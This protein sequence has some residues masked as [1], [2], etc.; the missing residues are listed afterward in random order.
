LSIILG[1][2]T[3]YGYAEQD[4]LK[5]AAADAKNEA[6]AAKT[7]RDWYKYA[8]LQLKHYTGDLTNKEAEELNV[9]PGK[10][11][12]SEDKAAYDSVFQDLDKRLVKGRAF[13]SY[14]EKV[15]RLE[16]ELANTRASLQAEQTSLKKEREEHLRMVAVKDQ[17]VQ[18]LTSELQKAHADNVADRDKLEKDMIAKLQELGGVSEE[19]EKV[20]KL[21]ATEVGTLQKNEKVLKE[22]I[23]TQQEVLDKTRSR[24]TPPDLQKFSAPKGEIVSLDSAGQTA[25]INLGSADHIRNQQGLTFSIFGH[26]VGGQGSMVRKGALEVVNVL[27][28]HLSQAKITETADPRVNPIQRKDVLVNPAWSPT[29]QEHVA[30][31]GLI[32]FTGQGRDQIDELKR[33]LEKQNVVVDAYL[34]LRDATIKGKM[35]VKTDYL[36]LGEQPGFDANA[37]VREG[38]ARFDRK[39]DILSKMTDMQQEATRLGVTVVPLRRFVALTGYQVP[40]G[41]SA[42]TGYSYESRIPRSSN[43]D[44]KAPEKKEPAKE[45]NK[46]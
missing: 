23:R 42:T 20:K 1:V 35:S 27:R 38:D 32:D 12:T 33:A 17:E 39:T 21:Y 29:M 24:L 26:G 14:R 40:P 25:W 46:Q 15:N 22:D 28:P 10:T 44:G 31:A 34:D 37:V 6:K 4:A 18:K 9:A 41:A 43:G 11:A 7:S 30:I 16:Q 45:E 13:E 36:I 2:T 8:A 19:L 5:K 3:Y